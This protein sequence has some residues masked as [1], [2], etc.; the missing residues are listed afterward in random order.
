[1][2]TIQP[3]GWISSLLCEMSVCLY[4]QTLSQSIEHFYDDR[5]WAEETNQLGFGKIRLY[6]RAMLPSTLCLKKPDP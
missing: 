6:S 2:R 1:M 5:L 3:S 4:F